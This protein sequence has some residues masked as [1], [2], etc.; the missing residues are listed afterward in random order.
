M[1]FPHPFRFRIRLILGDLNIYKGLVLAFKHSV[2]PP[3]G[4]PAVTFCRYFRGSKRNLL[5]SEIRPIFL[6][7]KEEHKSSI[8]IFTDG[9]K[10]NAGI[11]FGIFSKEFS[12]KGSLPG[13]ASDFTAESTV[14]FLAVK[15]IATLQGNA[16]NFTIFCDSKSVLQSIESFNSKHPIIL[17]I[18]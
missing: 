13:I 4:L 1:N 3:W 11:G 12:R 7:H 9:S 18:L 5:G 2:I 14:I 15:T 17:K 10:S 16:R 6:D 8:S